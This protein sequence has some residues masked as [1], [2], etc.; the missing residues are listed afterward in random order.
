MPRSD[1]SLGAFRFHDGLPASAGPSSVP[2]GCSPE[3]L[4][5]DL[6][7]TSLSPSRV[8]RAALSPGHRWTSWRP[9]S[10]SPFGR[11]T[12][13]LETNQDAFHRK[14]PLLVAKAFTSVTRPRVRARANHPR[15]SHRDRARRPD[16]LASSRRG[17]PRRWTAK[18]STFALHDPVPFRPHPSANSLCP[19][20]LSTR[21]ST[22]YAESAGAMS[23]RSRAPTRREG[24]KAS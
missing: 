5:E 24:E 13:R 12:D 22:F 8:H 23:A 21:L 6:P 2:A 10:S 20:C 14:V 18:Y 7:L 4:D 15:T 19:A 1:A 9:S 17:F 3:V 16:A 11:E